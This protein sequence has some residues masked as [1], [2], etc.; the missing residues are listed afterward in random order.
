MFSLGMARLCRSTTSVQQM[1]K[2]HAALSASLPSDDRWAAAAYL[3]FED[4]CNSA[5]RVTSRARSCQCKLA[6]SVIDRG[7]TTLHQIRSAR[8]ATPRPHGP[9][10]DV[11][12]GREPL[13]CKKHTQ[14]QISVGNPGYSSSIPS[15][16][17]ILSRSCKDLSVACRRLRTASES[18]RVSSMVYSPL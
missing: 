14:G 7:M 2:P 16:V 18:A 12:M 5:S 3:R 15:T 10:Q 13:V 17:S 1:T 8:Q 4:A 11:R 9:V 6:R